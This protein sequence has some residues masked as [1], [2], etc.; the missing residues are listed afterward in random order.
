MQI[1]VT[2]T[3]EGFS[4]NE[5]NRLFPGE[6]ED[7]AYLR[8]SE[9][10]G[11]DGIEWLYLGV[12]VNGQLRA[13]ATAFVTRYHLDTTLEGRLRAVASTLARAAPALL[14]PRMLALGSPVSERCLLGFAPDCGQAERS[15]LLG[16]LLEAADAQ[17][18][19]RGA[20][21][22]ALK[23]LPHPSAS[24]S[25]SLLARAGLR[26]QP[27]LATASLAL[28]Y[29]DLDGYLASLG[30]A[31]RK[32]LRRKLR[33]RSQ[34][35]IEW[36]SSLAGIG[37]QVMALYQQTLA[38]APMRLETLT[39]AWFSGVLAAMPGRAFC[40]CYWRGEH[41][42]AFNLVLHDG[43]CLLDKYI[44]MDYSCAR[45]LNLYFLSWL[46]NVRHAIAHGLRVYQSGQGLPDEKQRLGCTLEAN[47][48][49]YRHRNGL[50]D[51]T[52]GAAERL[53]GLHEDVPANT[54]AAR[55]PA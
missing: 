2:D 27:G 37:A 15:H 5:W 36:R 4:G 47:R 6:L 3:I 21:L 17:A 16:A 9:R 13:A 7:H 51:R 43:Q 52:M 53:F 32:D 18:Q 35:R 10:A 1:V 33:T 30:R 29:A 26:W 12:R 14:R 54:A 40:V 31:T 44:G 39:E 55:I 50:I 38:R 19:R 23:D 46:E 34:L 24:A 25:E 11:L 8:A 22:L 45:E 49:W 42:V 28:P 48:L 41:L 20:R